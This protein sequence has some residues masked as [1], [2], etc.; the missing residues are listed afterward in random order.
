MS[1]LSRI[2]TTIRQFA[3]IYLSAVSVFTLFRIILFITE[4]D[5]IDDAT[6]GNNILLSFIMG[7]RFDIVI[8]GY[9]LI[10][11]YFL[12]SVLSFF[13]GKYLTVKKIC[14]YYISLLFTLS[15]VICAV[16]V[17]YFNQ[18]FSRLSIT[19]FEWLNSPAFVFKM[20]FQEP[21]YWIM[22]IPLVLI[23]FIFYKNLK[24]ILFKPLT[25]LPVHNSLNI[26]LSI[27]IL[28]LMFL[29]IRGRI[30]K[31]SPI[32]SEERRVGKECRSRWSPYH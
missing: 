10:I 3:K 28:G 7:L 18:F 30:E 12:L 9:I 2:P 17:P 23:V 24:R 11:P 5:R 26:I 4:L 6:S 1:I 29:G 27:I 31:K 25:F 13:K 20:I 22:L 8:S 16:D 19:A 21:R 32:R 15:F 14:F